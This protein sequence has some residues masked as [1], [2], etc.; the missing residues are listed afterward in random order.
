MHYDAQYLS[1]LLRTYRWGNSSLRDRTCRR[2]CS[3]RELWCLRLSKLGTLNGN[4]AQPGSDFS[5]FEIFQHGII[6][7][8]NTYPGSTPNEMITGYVAQISDGLNTI[9]SVTF[10]EDS[11]YIG[12]TVTKGITRLGGFL[13]GGS[14]NILMFS[15]GIA[16]PAIQTR[17][18]N[19][20]N[21][22]HAGSNPALFSPQ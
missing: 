17:L 9:G 15:K 16:S 1:P 19:Q 3:H 4:V 22:L 11:N 12:A 20:I 8:E 21:I 13:Y 6:I 18:G 2:W 10:N 7:M 5:Q 14:L